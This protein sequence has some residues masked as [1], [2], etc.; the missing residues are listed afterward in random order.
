MNEKLVPVMTQVK[1]FI[2]AGNSLFTLVNMGTGKHFTFRL[3]APEIQKNPADPVLFV[4]VLA[5]PDNCSDYEMIGMLFS[6]CRYNH[7]GKSQFGK[8]CPSEVAFVWLI[9]KLLKGSLPNEV[10]IFHHGFCGKC[11][12]LL[13]DPESV[14]IG[15]GPICRSKF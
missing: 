7:W 6:G 3:Q 9:A 14:T 10:K 8:D 13:T 2:L 11:G 15:L 12:K 5:G 1:E 4:K